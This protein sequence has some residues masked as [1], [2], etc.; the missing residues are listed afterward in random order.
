M[1]VV[2]LMSKIMAQPYPKG[3]CPW[4]CFQ[5]PRPVTEFAVKEFLIKIIKFLLITPASVAVVIAVSSL[6]LC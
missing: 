1:T 6:E 5:L 4:S 2:G 3:A